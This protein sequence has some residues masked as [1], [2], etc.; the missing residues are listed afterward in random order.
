ME[1]LWPN[2]AR[3]ESFARPQCSSQ[4]EYSAQDCLLHRMTLRYFILARD[5]ASVRVMLNCWVHRIQIF[6]LTDSYQIDRN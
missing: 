1:L 3:L 2:P 6:E 5:V 4:A